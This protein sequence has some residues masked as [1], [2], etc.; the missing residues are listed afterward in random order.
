MFIQVGAT[1][2]ECAKMLKEGYAK[3]VIVLTLAKQTKKIIDGGT[4]G[5]IS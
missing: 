1:T 4:N 3:E 5:R 2:N